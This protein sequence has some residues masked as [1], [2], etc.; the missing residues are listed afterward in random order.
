LSDG[1]A[2]PSFRPGLVAFDRQKKPAK[3]FEQHWLALACV[4]RC[5]LRIRQINNLQI[6]N[7]EKI[8]V[9]CEE[10]LELPLSH[11]ALSG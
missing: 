10:L 1:D 9:A 4:K 6:A 11:V 3:S 8:V 2:I 7:F 5:D